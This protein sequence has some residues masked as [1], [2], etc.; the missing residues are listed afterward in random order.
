V[1][2]EFPVFGVNETIIFLASLIHIRALTLQN[3]LDEIHRSAPSPHNGVSVP[4]TDDVSFPSLSSSNRLSRSTTSVRSR[5]L[6]ESHFSPEASLNHYWTKLLT[7][8]LIE[9]DRFLLVPIRHHL[10]RRLASGFSDNPLVAFLLDLFD[11]SLD[12]S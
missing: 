11:D 8:R 1:T 4:S 5:R 10:I 12:L 7:L 3:R 9:L 2:V 6:F